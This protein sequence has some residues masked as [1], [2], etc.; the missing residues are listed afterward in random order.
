LQA[1]RRRG[2]F[3]FRFVVFKPFCAALAQGLSGLMN[4]S[5]LKQELLAQERHRL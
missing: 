2:R 4:G 1:V 3:L 5:L